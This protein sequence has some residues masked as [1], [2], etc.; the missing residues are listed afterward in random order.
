MEKQLFIAG[1]GGQGV[2]VAAK[3]LGMAA[4]NEGTD[5]T[6]FPAYEPS[7]RNGA[8]FA[9]VITSDKNV[10][11]CIVPDYDYM[12]VLD[13]RSFNEQIHKVKSGGTLI[14]NTSLIKGDCGRDDIN[15][16]NVPLNDITIE[17]GN[18]RLINVVLLGV[19]WAVTKMTK[20]ESLI[21]E[22]KR[23]F[24]GKANLVELNVK[25]FDTGA[26]YAS[27]QIQ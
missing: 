13:Q 18:E 19:I 8:S 6:F 7:V 3:M 20:R 10:E 24:A 4:A 17:L 23:M 15:I 11:S 26:E 14:V 22:I 25:A 9:T 1:F 21:E 12:A 16:V 27:Q 2:M 5:C